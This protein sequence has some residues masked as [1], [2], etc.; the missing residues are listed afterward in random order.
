MVRSMKYPAFSI[1]GD[2]KIPDNCWAIAS[3]PSVGFF[4]ILVK[5]FGHDAYTKAAAIDTTNMFDQRRRYFNY[6]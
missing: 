4:V 6:A 5:R 1:G 2:L 3:D